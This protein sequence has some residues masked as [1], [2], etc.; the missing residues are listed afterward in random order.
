MGLHRKSRFK[1]FIKPL[2][3]KYFQVANAFH[4]VVK[5]YFSISLNR[6]SRQIFDDQNFYLVWLPFYLP[7]E[8]KLRR[9]WIAESKAIHF[10]DVDDIGTLVSGNHIR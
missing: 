2:F 6:N 10:H 3:E 8:F 1:I 7:A 4:R 5:N 9:V